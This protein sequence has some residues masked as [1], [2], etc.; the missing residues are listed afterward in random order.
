MMNLK[1]KD[2]KSEKKV[3]ATLM[4]KWFHLIISKG[5]F[6]L[7][8]LAEQYTPFYFNFQILFLKFGY[9]EKATKFEKILHLKF[10][11]TQ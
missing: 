8:A 11:A 4:K 1:K 10:D 3:N 9:S 5:K 2:L 7:I 6:M